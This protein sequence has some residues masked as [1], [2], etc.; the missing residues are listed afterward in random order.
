MYVKARGEF[1][2][3]IKF[4]TLPADLPGPAAAGD[5]IKIYSI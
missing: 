4:L 2:R 3:F 5:W 1:L